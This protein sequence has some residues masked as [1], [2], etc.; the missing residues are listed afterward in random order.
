MIIAILP[1]I[2]QLCIRHFLFV[3][4]LLFHILVCITSFRLNGILSAINKIGDDSDAS[5]LRKM[6]GLSELLSLLI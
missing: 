6:L 4:R 5:S 2:C 3:F 1:R